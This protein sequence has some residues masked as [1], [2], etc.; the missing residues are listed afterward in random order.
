LY[1]KHSV[2]ENITKPDGSSATSTHS[3]SAV[4]RSYYESLFS[5]DDLN[6]GDQ[7]F[8]LNN[9]NCKLSNDESKSCEG[10][11][12]NAECLA[13]LSAMAH[14]KSPGLDGFPAE[15]YL[16]FWPVLERIM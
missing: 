15:F 12:T 13:A 6:T 3:I 1:R 16:K 5:S 10:H 8:F 14:N 11:V 9:V 7:G 2:I 4:I